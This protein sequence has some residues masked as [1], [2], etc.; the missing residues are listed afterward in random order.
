[1]NRSAVQKRQ[2][3]HVQAIVLVGHEHIGS[4]K[5]QVAHIA[6]S[7]QLFAALHFVVPVASVNLLANLQTRWRTESGVSH[8]FD[9]DVFGD[10]VRGGA[11]ALVPDSDRRYLVLEEGL[12]LRQGHL[13]VVEVVSTGG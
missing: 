5:H 9:D 3:D 11:S 7:F 10:V 8:S 2:S 4:V 12:V 6:L 13:R 1:M